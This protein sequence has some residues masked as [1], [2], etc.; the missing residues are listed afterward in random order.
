MFLKGVGA[1]NESLRFIIINYIFKH[2]SG[3]KTS[4]LES[5]RYQ[6]RP[7]KARFQQNYYNHFVLARIVFSSHIGAQNVSLRLNYNKLYVYIHICGQN[8]FAR[9][10]SEPI[11]LF[12]GSILAQLVKRNWLLRVVTF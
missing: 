8:S 1:P 6:K 3:I 11:K 4:L 12:Q 7:F 9:V 5:I 10:T 2:T